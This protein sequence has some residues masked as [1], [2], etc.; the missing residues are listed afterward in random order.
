MAVE[1]W[2]MR[3]RR[4]LTSR[5]TDI[6]LAQLPPERRNRLERVKS[7]ERWREPLCAYGILRRA[8]REQ[9]GWLELP[10][11][12]AAP[13]GKP[14]FSAPVNVQFSLS[15]AHGAV[16]VALSMLPVGVDVERIRPVSGQMM[17]R[18]AQTDSRQIFFRSWVRREARG[19][20]TGVG[21]DTGPEVPPS[22]GEHYYELNLFEGYAAGVAGE[23][24]LGRI[25]ILEQD[26]LI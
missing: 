2:A 4:P 1:L 10:G 8:L 23:E 24:S 16:L 5:E 12:K 18:L 13:S 9:Y 17:R 7:R 22:A 25:R 20:R 15:H 14:M 21:I 26:T 19:K 6:L 3:L 11:I